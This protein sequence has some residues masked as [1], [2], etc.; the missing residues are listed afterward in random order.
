M[1]RFT[2][3]LIS[4]ELK[5]YKHSINGQVK[6]HEVDSF[7]VVHNIQ[8]FYYC[9]W[10]RTKYLE[11]C[12]IPFTHNTF[13]K[14][15]PLMTVHHEMD[16]FNSLRLSDGYIVHSRASEI[17]KSSIT[18]D[19]IITDINGNPI[20]RLSSVLV[21]VNIKTNQPENIPDDLRSKIIGLEKSDIKIR[22]PKQ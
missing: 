1:K 8:Y 12:G 21:Y 7:R 16:Y 18:L 17:G 2:P 20:I 4:E 3:E 19:N 9:E 5:L 10:A 11:F 15:E 6:F 22:E 13:T 14:S